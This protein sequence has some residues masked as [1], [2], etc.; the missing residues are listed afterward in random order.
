MALPR[1]QFGSNMTFSLWSPSDPLIESSL[2]I[3]EPSERSLEMSPSYGDVAVVPAIAIDLKGQRLGFGG[4]YYDRW[5]SAH[6]SRLK[7][8][9]GV[10]FPTCFS[11]EAFQS[12]PHD[13][14][15]DLCLTG[16]QCVNISDTGKLK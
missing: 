4:G 15:V 5:L 8:I 13:I 3:L 16:E 1:V 9:I 2:G 11:T 6:R 7:L 10:V 14:S 12:E